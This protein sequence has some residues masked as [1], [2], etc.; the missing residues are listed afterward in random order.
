MLSLQA[1]TL[2]WHLGDRTLSLEFPT[3]LKKIVRDCPCRVRLAHLSVDPMFSLTLHF[4]RCND[5]ACAQCSLGRFDSPELLVAVLTVLPFGPERIR[6]GALL[7]EGGQAQAPSRGVVTPPT[8]KVTSR[9]SASARSKTRLDIRHVLYILYVTWRASAMPRKPAGSIL[10]AR[11][12]VCHA[13]PPEFTKL[14]REARLRISHVDP[15]LQERNGCKSTRKL[16]AI[17]HLPGIRF[18]MPFQIRPISQPVQRQ[19]EFPAATIII[20]GLTSAIGGC[21]RR[22]LAPL[23][24]STGGGV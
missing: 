13:I 18:C 24:V 22:P 20:A 21:R 8:Q 14:F 12:V 10:P 7:A 2:T 17:R 9:S 4:F 5:W 15:L 16:R 1:N 3:M 11:C 19:L 6:Q 23:N